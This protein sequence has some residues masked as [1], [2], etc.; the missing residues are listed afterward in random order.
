MRKTIRYGLIVC[1]LFGWISHCVA[2]SNFTVS[3]FVKDAQSGESLIGA[4]IYVKDPL[5]GA[6][7][8]QYGFYSLTLPSGQYNVFISYLGYEDDSVSIDLTDNVRHQFSAQPKA[9]TTKTVEI[10]ATRDNQNIESTEMGVTKLDMKQIELLP[11][12]MGEVDLLKTIQLLPGVQSAGDGNTGFYVRGGGP[13]QNLILLDEAVVY[14]ASHLL[15]FFSVFNANAVNSVKLYK[16]GMPA[17]YGG[18]LASVVD[19]TMKEGNM[20]KYE[21]DGGVGLISSRL[22]VQGP[23]KKDTSSFIISARRTYIDVLVT[24]LIPDTSRFAGSRYYFYDLNGKFNYILSDKDRLYLSGY[25]GRDIFN[26]NNNEDD[27]LVQT[28]WGN[29]TAS[30]RWNHLFSNRLFLNTSL[31]YTDYRFRFA[32][33]QGDF[34]FE[35]FSGIKDW[36]LHFDFLYVPSARHNIKFG[37]QNIYHTFTPGNISASSDEVEFNTGAIIRQHAFEEALYINDEFSVSDRLKIN[38]GLRFST[39]WQIGPFTRY[40]DNELSPIPDTTVYKTFDKVASYSGLEPRLSLRYSLNHSSSFKAGFTHNYQYIHLA[41]LSAVSLPTDIWVPSSDVVKPQIG[42]QYAI[43]YFRNFKENTYETSVEVYYKNMRNLIEYKEGS[44]PDDNV[45]N[46]PDNNFTFGEG[47]SYGAEFFFKKRLGKLNGWVGYTWSKTM[48]QFDD[49]NEGK[50][51]PA[52]YDRRHDLSAVAAYEAGKRW[53]FSGTFVYGTGNAITLPS[54]RYSIEGQIVNEYGERN[55]IRMAPYHRLDVA[56]TLKGKTDKRFQSSWTFA[57]YNVYSRAN[58]YFIYFDNE[59]ELEQGN[60]EVTAKQVSL[61]PVLP[62][63]TWN[64]KF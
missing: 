20:K 52:R 28:P 59:G 61:F 7:T 64:F 10:T 36:N 31:I 2:Q 13:D 3:G 1:C 24:P 26:F 49:L 11:A 39:F 21:V 35:L 16:G 42:T 37:L 22:T 43:G 15:G 33:E 17:N 5:V 19:V 44:L 47:Y 38:A 4:S 25:L 58:P 14:N 55:G 63:V 30:L 23:I 40:T 57:V 6:S 12:F 27:F 29:S 53:V 62:S 32:A 18:R 54:A 46:N 50:E 8:N 9:I 60:L 45:A 48:R 34:N 51:F 41:S 56:A